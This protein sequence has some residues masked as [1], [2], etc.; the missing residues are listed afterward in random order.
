MKCWV[1]LRSLEQRSFILIDSSTL[2]CKQFKRWF[3]TM[4]W[5]AA[6]L[7]VQQIVSGPMFKV[8]TQ[9]G[10]RKGKRCTALLLV[11][12]LLL[13]RLVAL[14]LLRLVALLLLLVAL[15]LLLV[16]LL[17]LLLLL[18]LLKQELQETNKER[19]FF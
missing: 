17:L 8:T 18:L 14:L 3:E 19:Y 15:L 11:T 5:F 10:A 6:Q 4:L 12:V 2:Y 16:A 7:S 1:S 13:L 9:G